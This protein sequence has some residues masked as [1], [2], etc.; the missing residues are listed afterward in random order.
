MPRAVERLFAP[1][2]D[3]VAD[4]FVRDQAASGP[5]A[6]GDRSDGGPEAQPRTGSA[7]KE[8]K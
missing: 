7:C 8:L 5:R 6:F 2:F 3:V 1:F 4:F